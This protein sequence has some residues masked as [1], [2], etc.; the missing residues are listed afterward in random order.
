MSIRVL[1]ELLE[2]RGVPCIL[3]SPTGKAA[4]RLAEA[5]L[6]DAYTIH[7]QLF[8]PRTSE[9]PGAAS[10]AQASVRVV[11]PGRP[12]PSSTS[13]DDRLATAGVAAVLGRATHSPDFRWRQGSAGR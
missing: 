5:T 13:I 2:R 4:K 10:R 7:R 1:V 3:L 12:N 11:P 8:Q 6:R 9:G